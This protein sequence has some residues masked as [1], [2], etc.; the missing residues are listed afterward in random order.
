[1]LVLSDVADTARYWLARKLVKHY[2]REYVVPL[3]RHGLEW[4]LEL[5][6]IIERTWRRSKGPR[7]RAM[8]S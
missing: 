4:T 8:A 1:M 3:G 2:A 5:I 7:R 6:N